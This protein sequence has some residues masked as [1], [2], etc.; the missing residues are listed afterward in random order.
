MSVEAGRWS[1]RE[2][3]ARAPAVIA[4]LLSSVYQPYVNLAPALWQQT[5]ALLAEPYKHDWSTFVLDFL[6][7]AVE[8]LSALT[9]YCRHVSQSMPFN[10]PRCL[11]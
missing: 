2:A 6:L 9:D 1:Q 7:P 10:V 3:A 5:E 11:S 4:A 8:L